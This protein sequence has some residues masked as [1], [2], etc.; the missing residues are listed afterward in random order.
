[1]FAHLGWLEFC[2]SCMLVVVFLGWGAAFLDILCFLSAKC[3]QFLYFGFV[4]LA[5]VF[6]IVID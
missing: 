5:C 1:M 4:V 2:I 6:C 3:S